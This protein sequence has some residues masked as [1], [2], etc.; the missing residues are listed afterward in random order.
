MVGTYSFFF[1]K[2]G[3]I[4]FTAVVIVANYKLLLIQSRWHLLH[5]VLVLLSI[6]S[7]VG[8]AFVVNYIYLVDFDF[9]HLWWRILHRYWFAF[10]VVPISY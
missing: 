2:V 9:Y 4:C 8:L 3:T 1:F 10:T 6:G 7:W 5:V